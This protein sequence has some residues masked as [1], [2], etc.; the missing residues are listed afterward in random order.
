MLIRTKSGTMKEII[1]N[2][3][4][5]Y[6]YGI[7]R[8][9]SRNYARKE[10]LDKMKR[11]QP[12]LEQVNR[13]LDKL[14][15]QKYLSD[16]NRARSIFNQFNG[17]ESINKIKNRM[18]QKGVKKD[19]VENFIEDCI[20]NQEKEYE[21]QEITSEV[22]DAYDLVLKKFKTYDYEKRD[23]MTRFLASKGFKYD[24]INKAIIKLKEEA[25]E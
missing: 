25:E 17:R 5:L 11:L 4:Q 22:S 3:Q 23:K 14:E 12:D 2:E 16:H 15:D 19:V 9:S 13:V 18:L 6:N 21:E 20:L 7:N 8:L 1:Y 24:S 10:L